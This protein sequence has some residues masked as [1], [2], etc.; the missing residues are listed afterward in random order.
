MP[1]WGF[2]EQGGLESLRSIGLSPAPDLYFIRILISCMD[3][4]PPRWTTQ[5]QCSQ[6]FP[7]PLASHPGTELQVGVGWDSGTTGKL[8]GSIPFWESVIQ[9]EGL[10]G[11][12]V[13][14]LELHSVYFSHK[15]RVKGQFPN[16]LQLCCSLDLI[17]SCLHAQG[18][19]LIFF[20]QL[21]CCPK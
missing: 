14:C 19:L 9:T 20:I 13:F 18:S 12:F 21:F 5:V 3:S 10:W 6:D 16:V 17:G 4:L 15:S 1:S 11:L 8:G 7:K 2:C